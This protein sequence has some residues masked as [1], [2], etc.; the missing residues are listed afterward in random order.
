MSTWHL[1]EAQ[2]RVRLL[3][4]EAKPSRTSAIRLYAAISRSWV[5][6]G[7]LRAKLHRIIEAP[8]NTGRSPGAGVGKS[9][10]KLVTVDPRMHLTGPYLA[11]EH[12][13]HCAEGAPCHPLQSNT[14]D[15]LVAGE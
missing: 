13:Q 14:M 11:V 7:T 12:V 8:W 15:H 10:A 9:R 3:H 6:A 5:S 2:A 1:T 4:L